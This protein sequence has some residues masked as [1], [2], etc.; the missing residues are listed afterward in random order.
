MCVGLPH[1]SEDLL[2]WKFNRNV[3]WV[4]IQ[5]QR[6]CKEQ[7]SRS[8]EVK[9]GPFC[10]ISQPHSLQLK[11]KGALFLLVLLLC[12]VLFPYPLQGQPALYH[13]PVPPAVI[14]VSSLSHKYSH[15]DVNHFCAFFSLLLKTHF[16]PLSV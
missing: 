6:L 3:R 5:P 9:K 2:I 16:P 4:S 15:H 7:E 11:S 14:L 12:Q 1:T 10:Q 8:K 13:P